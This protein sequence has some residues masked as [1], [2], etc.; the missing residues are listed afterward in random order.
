DLGDLAFLV[1]DAAGG[2]A[3]ESDG[4]GALDHVNTFVVKGVSEIAAEVA[5][6][7]EENVVARAEAADGE[8][9]SLRA[10]LAG[11]QAD[12]GYVAQ[13]IAQRVGALFLHDLLADY[14]DG[15]RRVLQKLGVFGRR[16]HFQHLCADFNG[17]GHAADANGH[18]T[19]GSEI[20]RSTAF[21]EKQLKRL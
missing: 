15:L 6:S 12:A 2:S 13:G 21:A 4:S 19:G 20:E 11:R 8:V 10:A 3:A 17:G 16:Q 7:V 5:H 14:V 18:G 1:H 9:V